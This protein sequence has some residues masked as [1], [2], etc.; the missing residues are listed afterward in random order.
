MTLRR[1]I[2]NKF[3]V[4]VGL[5]HVSLEK[6]RTRLHFECVFACFFV[7]V[8]ESCVHLNEL[9]IER[10]GERFLGGHDR[11]RRQ[12]VRSDYAKDGM[13]EGR[14]IPAGRHETDDVDSIARIQMICETVRLDVDPAA[15]VLDEK[16]ASRSSKRHDT[17][18]ARSMLHFPAGHESK[19]VIHLLD[20]AIKGITGRRRDDRD[21]IETLNVE[22]YARELG[23]PIEFRS[24]HSSN[25]H[26]GVDQLEWQGSI[27]IARH[28]NREVSETG[29]D[30]EICVTELVGLHVLNDALDLCPS[31]VLPTREHS[32][33][34]P[35]R[36]GREARSPDD[37]DRGLID[38]GR[39]FARAA[40]PSHVYE[41]PLLEWTGQ[42]GRV[43]EDAVVLALNEEQ[44][45]DGFEVRNDPA[46]VYRIPTRRLVGRKNPHVFD[47]GQQRQVGSIDRV[48]I[49]TE[50]IHQRVAWNKHVMQH[51][52]VRIDAI[53]GRH[54]SNADP[55]SD[56]RPIMPDVVLPQTDQR[57][58]LVVSDGERK[59]AVPHLG[60]LYR[61]LGLYPR[62]D[63]RREFGKG[64]APCRGKRRVGFQI[65][66]FGRREP[67]GRSRKRIYPDAM[68]GNHV[69]LLTG[70]VNIDAAGRILHEQHAP[71]RIIIRD[72][73]L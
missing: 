34:R 32:V 22:D 31:T 30:P 37:F 3:G 39:V 45:P 36:R 59:H 51:W 7:R 41:I 70:G 28:L 73:P 5:G 48:D 68:G 16:V 24:A 43:Y 4:D 26:A 54:P 8:H 29:G 10:S 21:V 12:R 2:G 25:A 56:E 38:L 13:T 20:G 61:A 15:F 17:L 71:R 47:P 53:L 55:F 6:E 40:P 42:T 23:F 72:R 11:R 58:R 49:G 62:R 67:V 60:I 64:H 33:E 63:V 46:N 50:D 65:P 69:V 52:I 1:Q 66:H 9:C 57:R 44:I 19:Q 18:D 35:N 14:R 27:Q